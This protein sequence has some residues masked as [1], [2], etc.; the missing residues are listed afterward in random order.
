MTIP[1]KIIDDIRYLIA[2][3]ICLGM[4]TVDLLTAS[5]LAKTNPIIKIINKK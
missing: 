1:T 2:Q 5:F 4:S 3:S